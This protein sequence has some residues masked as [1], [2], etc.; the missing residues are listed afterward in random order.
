MA[1]PE[2]GA[3][4]KAVA[5]LWGLDTGGERGPKR[6]L[7]LDQILETAIEIGDGE[8]LAAISMGR[9]A[10]QL[11]FTAMSLYRY[12][13][14]K[15]TLFEMLQDRVLG[16]PPEIVPGMPWRDGLRRW[17]QAEFAA[18]EAHRWW[19]DIPVHDPP[20][21][22][23]NMAWLEAGLATFDDTP[24]PPPLRMQLLMNMTFYVMGRARVARNIDPT[25]S[26][27]DDFG[28]VLATLIDPRRFPRVIAAF[29]DFPFGDD[30]IDWQKLD[31]D[32]GL[33]RMLDGY[34]NFIRSFET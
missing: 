9:I 22:P 16:L 18:I 5:L 26:S 21:G 4:P 28:A 30:E 6:G 7:S 23:N 12:V 1:T 29:A 20:M 33:E 34:E 24:L 31:F 8:G 15:Q 10:K 25:D 17:A 13:D 11:G 32:F 19:L 2:D 14:S 3:I 27:D